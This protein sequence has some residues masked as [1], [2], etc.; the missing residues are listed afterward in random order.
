MKSQ[1]NG[2]ELVSRGG[3]QPAPCV[4][5]VR[6]SAGIPSNEHD[7]PVPRGLSDRPPLPILLTG[8][9]HMPMGFLV[10]EAQEAFHKIHL[11]I[12]FILHIPV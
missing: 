10:T 4:H 7:P 11:H 9:H 3:V 8:L 2:I 1:Q 12:L 5:L 6:R